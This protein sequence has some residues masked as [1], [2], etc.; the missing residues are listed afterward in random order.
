MLPRPRNDSIRGAIRRTPLQFEDFGSVQV[1]PGGIYLMTDEPL[2]EKFRHENHKEL[3]N[4]CGSWPAV[5]AFLLALQKLP[6]LPDNVKQAIG[7]LLAF[8]DLICP[9]K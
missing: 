5:K 3:A 8:G 7:V 6:F 2:I 4:L 1:G 9:G